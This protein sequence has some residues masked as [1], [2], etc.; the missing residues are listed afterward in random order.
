M[1]DG[2]LGCIMLLFLGHKAEKMRLLEP[3]AVVCLIHAP[4]PTQQSPLCPLSPRPLSH[5][6]SESATTTL[7]P[8]FPPCRGFRGFFEPLP[9]TAEKEKII[10]WEANYHLG[11]EKSHCL[12]PK[13]GSIPHNFLLRA[14]ASSSVDGGQ[15]SR[16][17]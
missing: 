13:C 1:R 5:A 2:E 9:I 7:Q 11:N 17:R 14:A 4:V 12:L 15:A 3:R 6:S 16:G 10:C 8:G